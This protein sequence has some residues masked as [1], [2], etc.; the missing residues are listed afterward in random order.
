[1]RYAA[2]AGADQALAAIDEIGRYDFA[3][4]NAWVR[5]RDEMVSE[6]VGE[7]VYRKAVTT[8]F[9]ETAPGDHVAAFARWAG[10]AHVGVYLAYVDDDGEFKWHVPEDAAGSIV[11]YDLVFS[12]DRCGEP[13]NPALDPAEH[14]YDVP[15]AVVPIAAGACVLMLAVCR[16]CVEDLLQTVHSISGSEDGDIIRWRPVEWPA[17]D[18]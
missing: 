8:W 2:E 9:P 11:Q 3:A 7:M 6:K 5:D 1:M 17:L 4:V 13:L 12:C 14:A 18:A 16:G 15:Y 10:M